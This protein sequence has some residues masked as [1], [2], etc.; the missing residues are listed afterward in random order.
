MSLGRAGHLK[1]KKHDFGK[2]RT[3]EKNHG[4]EEKLEFER[5][6]HPKKILSLG[7]A[8]HPKKIMRVKKL[9][10][11]KGRTGKKKG[12]KGGEKPLLIT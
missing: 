2:G 10:F 12:K 8:R 6:G 1:V 3:S 4:G 5:A 7:R 11:G 9:D